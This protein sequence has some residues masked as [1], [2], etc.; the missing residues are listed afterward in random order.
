MDPAGNAENIEINDIDKPLNILLQFY[1]AMQHNKSR[2]FTKR[3]MRD[4]G[5][6]N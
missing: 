3:V 2:P 5:C 6:H 1:C 4:I